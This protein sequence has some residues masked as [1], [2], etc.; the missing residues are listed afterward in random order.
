MTRITVRLLLAVS[1]LLIAG[2]AF[3]SGSA[4]SSVTP[5]EAQQRLAEGNARFVAGENTFPHFDA[6]RRQETS[7]NGQHPF[8]TVIACSDSRVPVEVLFDQGIGDVFVIRVAG[9]V[10]DTDE[11]GSIEYGVDHLGTP[12]MVVLGHTSCGAVTAV[13]TG[14]EVHGSIPAL[15]D[16][17][18]PAAARAKAA[19]PELEA[20]ALVPFAVKENVWRSI[21]DLLTHSPAV[22][23]RAADGRVLVVGAV[24]DLETGAVEW[25]GT[26]PAQKLLLEKHGGSAKR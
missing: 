9:N 7:H 1:A 12:V 16:N 15:V 21:A 14:A 26:H 6:A 19:H 8:A 25:M 18:E 20:E 11:I 5:A 22:A 17:I 2:Q 23:E 10:S 4:T 3:A 13:V 24:Y